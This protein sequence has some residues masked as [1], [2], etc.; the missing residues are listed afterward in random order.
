MIIYDSKP[1]YGK[2]AFNGCM[3]VSSEY[4]V[5]GKQIFF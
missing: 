4:V 1:T 3:G 5:R 2:V